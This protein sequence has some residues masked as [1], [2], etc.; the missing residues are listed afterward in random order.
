MA[1]KKR[2]WYRHPVDFILEGEVCAFRK[3][4]IE[5][6]SNNTGKDICVFYG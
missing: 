2:I 4:A 3:A 6:A 5:A 1:L